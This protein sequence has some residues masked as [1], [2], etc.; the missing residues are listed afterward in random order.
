MALWYILRYWELDLKSNCLGEQNATHRIWDWSLKIHVLPMWRT[1]LFIPT[2]KIWIIPTAILTSKSCL[3]ITN[4][5]FQT[6]PS[7]SSLLVMSET[8]GYDL[9]WA[10]IILYPQ[11]CKTRSQIVGQERHYHSQWEKLGREQESWVSR[12]FKAYEGKFC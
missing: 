2:P 1:D 3:N 12:K 9:S 7:Q 11:T 8:W 6:S 10:Q 4:F 5:K